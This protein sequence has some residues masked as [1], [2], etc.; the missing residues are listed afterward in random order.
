MSSPQNISYYQHRRRRLIS[1]TLC[2][3]II[4]A[5]IPRIGASLALSAKAQSVL[6]GSPGD[7]IRGILLVQ[8]NIGFRILDKAV[9]VI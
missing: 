5:G 7:R 3:K 2:Y 6:V 9:G 1:Q 4:A 8:Y